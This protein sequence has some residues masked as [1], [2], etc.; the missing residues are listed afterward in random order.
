MKG[1]PARPRTIVAIGRNYVNHAKELKNELP[2]NPFWFLKP[3]N[4]IV[5]MPDPILL[6]QGVGEVHHE[7]ELAVVIGSDKASRVPLK[8]AF[9]HVA[10]YAIAVDITGRTLQDEAKSKKL[11]WS[12]A[13]GFDTFLPLGPF[14]PKELIADPKKI[15]L[16]LSINGEERQR[17][18]VADMVFDVAQLITAVTHS[19]TL[20]KG[21][22]ILTGTPSGVGP[23]N[24]GDTVTFGCNGVNDEYD[25][26]MTF[27]VEAGPF[28][29]ME[30]LPKL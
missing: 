11:P 5:Q 22:I 2:K 15:E 24:P 21:D 26:E 25:R 9:D 4:S 30:T 6:P 3:A 13:K 19:M 1:F 14:I 8:E 20:E 29:G 16:W 27:K 23:M 28:V 7:I 12:R 17:N 10:G 18:V